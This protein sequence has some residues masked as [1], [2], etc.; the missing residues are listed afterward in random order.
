VDVIGVDIIDLGQ[1]R[2]TLVQAFQRQT[3]GGVDPRG[4]QDGDGNA[5]TL[6][7]VAQLALGIDTPSGAG[8]LRIQAPGLVDLRAATIA[9]NPCRAYVNEASW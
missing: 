5:A 4:A 7:P 6:A 2:Q 1:R 3:V 9:V 8:A